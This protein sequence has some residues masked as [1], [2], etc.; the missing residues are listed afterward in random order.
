VVPA[1]S[2]P[3]QR[4]QGASPRLARAA[5]SNLGSGFHPKIDWVNVDLI[6]EADLQLDLRERLP[7]DDGSVSDIYSEHSSST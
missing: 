2:S 1:A 5:A 4:Q 3:R 7:F 6:D